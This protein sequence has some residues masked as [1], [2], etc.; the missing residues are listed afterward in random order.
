MNRLGD[1]VPEDVRPMWLA[2]LIANLEQAEPLLVASF[3]EKPA[4]KPEPRKPL[5]NRE[6][7][8][9]PAAERAMG[10]AAASAEDDARAAGIR[11]R[12][13]EIVQKNNVPGSKAWDMA[14]AE[15]K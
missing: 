1:R 3:P 12:A 10:V 7:A 11:N 4:E 5:T 15:A 8:E 14:V 9:T 6:T 2:Q 13:H